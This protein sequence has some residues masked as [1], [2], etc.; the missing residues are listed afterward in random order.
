MTN[1]FQSYSTMCGHATIAIAKLVVDSLQSGFLDKFLDRSRLH[2]DLDKKELRIPIHVPCGLVHATVPCSRRGE[3]LESLTID[4]SR[5]I[6]YLSVP[7]YAYALNVQIPIPLDLRWPELGQRDH[8]TTDI[9]YGGAFYIVCAASELGFSS[10][11]AN[12]DLEG[13][14]RASR[15]IKTA[16]NTSD[17]L[18]S[19][20]LYHPEHDE[21]QFLYGTIV[22]DPDLGVKN[23]AS[24]GAETSICFFSNAQIDRSP[25]GSGVQARVALAH[26]R[27]E[28]K[29]G[30]E[31]TYH[32]PVSN[33]FGEGGFVGSAVE[34]VEFG[35]MKAV[36]V[37]VSGYAKYTG[38]ATYVVE[39][40]DRIGEGFWFDELYAKQ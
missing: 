24:I 18:R 12:P 1:H 6:S 39:D 15:R 28:H 9:A 2:Y 11:L 16:F 26:A 22:T 23:D 36:V 7:S 17:D 30:E 25:T 4:H 32:S 38:A 29:V 27:D 34:E 19:R 10:S 40:G 14:T 37:R 8:V 13:L 5:P 3:G 33:A 21:L 31:R 20:R 35:G